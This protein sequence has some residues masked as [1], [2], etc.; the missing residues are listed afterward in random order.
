[1]PAWFTFISSSRQ[2]RRLHDFSIGEG[3]K[4]FPRDSE[5]TKIWWWKNI[6]P[7]HP[8]LTTTTIRWCQKI[9]IEY[10]KEEEANFPFFF[11]LLVECEW[12]IWQR[13]EGKFVRNFLISLPTKAGSSTSTMTVKRLIW[14]RQNANYESWERKWASSSTTKWFDDS[15]RDLKDEC[16]LREQS[17]EMGKW[18][19][20]N[21]EVE[22]MG[23]KRY[24]YTRD[25]KWEGFYVNPQI[26][27]NFFLRF[28]VAALMISF[29]LS[30]Y[31]CC[32]NYAICAFLSLTHGL[33]QY[34][35]LTDMR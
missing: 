11:R 35:S 18:R 12:M 27:K 6:F 26:I 8:T 19:R 13:R 14:H 22:W 21:V 30:V 2:R 28:S 33:T 3:L 5:T 24:K 10:E 1:M 29:S 4:L 9:A 31:L 7:S 16:E 34:A 32:R 23:M 15:A 20:K 25:E 17:N